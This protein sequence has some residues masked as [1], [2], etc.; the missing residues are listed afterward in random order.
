MLTRRDFLKSSAF[1]GAGAMLFW[2]G[3]TLYARTD[4]GA[5]MAVVAAAQNLLASSI[6]KYQTPLVIP[7]A[8]PR[9]G[10][11]RVRG[12]E[13]DTVDYYEIAVK[14]FDQFI[15]PQ[16]MN[17]KTT[18]WGYGSARHPGTFNYPVLYD[19][20]KA[21]HPRAR[22]MDQWP[23]RRAWKV[24]AAPAPGRPDAALGQPTRRAS[25]ARFT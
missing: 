19:R 8:M 1:A 2:K 13:H 12:S 5:P 11:I 3:G 16:I 14:Q 25:G 17:R 7:P 15:L 21:R 20:G 23:G 24:S 18:V 9:V 4:S 6:P 22:E 10:R